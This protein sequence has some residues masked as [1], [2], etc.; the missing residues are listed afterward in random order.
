MAVNG[1]PN[2]LLARLHIWWKPEYFVSNKIWT[3]LRK[4]ILEK[5][6]SFG[7]EERGKYLEKKK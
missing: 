3:S 1:K 5:L 7:R 4:T 2:Q 6:N